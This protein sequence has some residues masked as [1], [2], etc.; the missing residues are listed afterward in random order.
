MTLGDIPRN[1]LD[2]VKAFYQEHYNGK[3]MPADTYMVLWRLQDEPGEFE[4]LAKGWPTHSP[5]G[6]PPAGSQAGVSFS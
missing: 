4:Q 6:P 5:D 1:D 2:A 3:S